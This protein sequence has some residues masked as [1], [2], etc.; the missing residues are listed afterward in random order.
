MTNPQH[1][2]LSSVLFDA[3]QI[4]ARVKEIGEQISRDYPGGDLLLIGVLKGAIYFL[5]DLSRAI[6]SSHAIDFMGASSYGGGTESSGLVKITKDLDTDVRGKHLVIVEDIYDTGHTMNIL[7]NLLETH[8]P[9]SI[10]LCSLVSKRK[11]HEYELPIDYVGFEI[12]DVFIVGYGLDYDERYR[13]LD[14]IGVLKPEIY[15]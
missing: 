3:E 2:D 13:H 6:T 5:S 8:A 10:K 11:A 15:S 4:Q 1:A 7:K 14:V 12:E 9:A